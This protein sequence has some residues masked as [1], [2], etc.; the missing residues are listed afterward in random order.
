MKRR[1]STMILL[2]TRSNLC[3]FVFC[4]CSCRYGIRLEDVVL[5]TETG[6]E[7]LSGNLATSATE[8]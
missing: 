6:Y 1:A 2:L 7:I 8:P 5:V 4:F 3:L